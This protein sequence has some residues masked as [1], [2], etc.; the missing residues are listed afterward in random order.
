MNDSFLDEDAMEMVVVLQLWCLRPRATSDPCRRGTSGHLGLRGKRHADISERQASHVDETT[1][2]RSQAFSCC[3][4]I[5]ARN[6]ACSCVCVS[7]LH[8]GCKFLTKLQVV[9]MT[10]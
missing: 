1:D 5:L 4:G 6:E 3:C 9:H 8:A 10:G 2:S 7:L